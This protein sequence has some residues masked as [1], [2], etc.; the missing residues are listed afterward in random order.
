VKCGSGQR[1]TSSSLPDKPLLI[2][3]LF[4]DLGTEVMQAWEN[5]G[6][7][8]MGINEAFPLANA[9]Y[10]LPTAASICESL[11]RRLCDEPDVRACMIWKNVDIWPLLSQWLQNI[12]VQHIPLLYQRADV[13]WQKLVVD[14]AYQKAAVIAGG[15]VMDHYVIARIAEKANLPT[16]SYHYGGFLGFSLLPKHERYDFAECDYFLCGGSGAAEAFNRPSAQ[17]HW[18]TSVKRAIPV[19]TGVP[20][21]VSHMNS[22]LTKSGSQPSRKRVMVI[23]NA[24]LGDCRDNGFQFSPEIQYWR[25]TRRLV[26]RLIQ[27]TDLD[28]IVKPPLK[29][30]YPQM[31]NP[32]IDWLEERRFPNVN[33]LYEVPLKDCLEQADAYIFES[34]STPLLQIAAT[35]KPILLYMNQDDY[36]L[37]S[38]AADALRARSI[39]FAETEKDFFEQL[40]EFLCR[41]VWNIDDVDDTFL[42]DYAIGSGEGT[43]SERIAA[44]LEMTIVSRRTQSLTMVNELN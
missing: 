28:I 41:P 40:E 39:V 4:S 36:L 5:R 18:N 27:E 21:I 29:T 34:P 13:V 11:W 24:L 23:L 2:S 25:F 38:R 26:D 43:A 15:W 42:R 19:P 32:L 8:S 9:R 1:L 22:R 16:I 17:T 3:S 37:Q 12:I 35:N 7:E 30:R 6:G 10:V 20:W 44:F 14:N 33:I 31:P